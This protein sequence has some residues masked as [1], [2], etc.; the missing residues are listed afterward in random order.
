M[1]PLGKNSSV[2]KPFSSA[3]VDVAGYHWHT[4]GALYRRTYLDNVG[5]WNEELTGSQDWEY[6]ARVKLA[7]GQ[8]KFVDTVVGYWRQ[9]SHERVGTRSFRYDYVRSVMT[10]CASILRLARETGHCDSA[11]ERKLAKK[12]IAHAIELGASGY[13]AERFECLSQAASALRESAWLRAMVECLRFT[14]SFA[15]RWLWQL[16][17]A[18]RLA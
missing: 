13:P 3:P 5:P 12:L 15:D 10:A 6:Q 7:G 9:H 16:L 17:V 18:H 2:G 1:Q 11:L 8:G 4:M 14:P